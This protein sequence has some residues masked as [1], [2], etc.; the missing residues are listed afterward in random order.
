MD[1]VIGKSCVNFVRFMLTNSF[2][3]IKFNLPVKLRDRATAGRGI[4]GFKR[5][6]RNTFIK[7]YFVCG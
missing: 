5:W 4:T 7:H 1:W 2:P 6:S 3:N